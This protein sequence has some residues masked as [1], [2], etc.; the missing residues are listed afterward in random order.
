[1]VSNIN[2]KKKRKRSPASKGKGGGKAK[3]D[4]KEEE[5]LP[6]LD[7]FAGSSEEEDSDHDNRA[8][9]SIHRSTGTRQ[10]HQDHH[11]GG[12]LED[13]DERN[14]S[15]S[16]KQDSSDE[17]SDTGK[18][19]A[20]PHESPSK[21]P[22]TTHRKETRDKDNGDDS[23]SDE[24][25]E[26]EEMAAGMAGA[27]AKI[28][29]S[30]IVPPSKK[31]KTVDQQPKQQ[32]PVVLSKTKTPLQRQAEK[33]R[34]AE[35]ALREKRRANQERNHL[36]AFHI[37]LSVATSSKK[38]L[39]KQGDNGSNIQKELEEERLFRRVATRGVVALFNAI[40][41]HQKSGGGHGSRGDGGA[42]GTKGKAADGVTPVKKLTKHSFLDM[43]KTKA[44]ATTGA[45]KAIEDNEKNLSDRSEPPE[46]KWNA[47]RDD[48]MLN[49]KK[50]WDE[51]NDEEDD[52]AIPDDWSDK[53]D[54]EESSRQPRGTKSKRQRVG[55]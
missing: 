15:N 20:D 47:L 55:S 45:S 49:P 10:Q 28:L 43:I 52:E 41:D 11:D 16:S 54:Q 31:K 26:K 23:S 1:M 7:R 13:E 37:P 42:E 32:T 39:S 24:D 30:S 44:A 25:S 4:D 34:Q 48:F 5:E 36:A 33:E 27:M 3:H 14:C 6:D 12:V 38:S 51:T 18:G 22:S 9:N 17:E 8:P 2:H 29:G 53:E 19:Q 35:M 50:N 21:S 40:S 46:K